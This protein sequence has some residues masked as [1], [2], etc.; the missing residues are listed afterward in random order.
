[1][2]TLTKDFLKLKMLTKDL[3]KDLKNLTQTHRNKECLV[4][5]E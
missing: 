4:N 3:L 5:A 1:M 2:K